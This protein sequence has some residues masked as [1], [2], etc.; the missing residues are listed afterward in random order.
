MESLPVEVYRKCTHHPVG[1]AVV[2]PIRTDVSLYLN[3]TSE[4]MALAQKVAP[5]YD[6]RPPRDTERWPFSMP[7]GPARASIETQLS[8]HAIVV[9]V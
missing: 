4:G 2:R 7:L 3:V 1:S 5:L 9:C 6:D 8:V